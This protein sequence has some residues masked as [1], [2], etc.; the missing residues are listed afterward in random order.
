MKKLFGSILLG[1][2]SFAAVAG[3]N[4]PGAFPSVNT[5][6]VTSGLNVGTTVDY[7]VSPTANTNGVYFANRIQTNYVNSSNIT[8]G[9]YAAGGE[10]VLNISG[11]G[12]NDKEVVT[13]HQLNHATGGN[14]S[15]AI[16]SEAEIASIC[17]TCTIGTYGGFYF[18]NL[19]GL[20][21]VGNITN[22]HAFVNEDARA[23]YK[24]VGR[25]LSY[26]SYS[27]NKE[28]V[29]PAHPGIVAGRYYGASSIVGYG[30]QNASPNVHYFV[31]VHIPEAVT[32]T[33]LG[34]NVQA[35]TAGN[36]RE[37]LYTAVGG[38]PNTLVW[39]TG[40]ISTAAAGDKETTVSLVIKAGPYFL[41][42]LCDTTVSTAW[43]AVGGERM[44]D[45]GG[46]GPL[47]GTE[48][49]FINTTYGALPAGIG[50]LNYALNANQPRLWWRK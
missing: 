40:S 31:P 8:T 4:I 13:L 48:I 33:K 15:L 20:A 24:N 30:A 11:G 46:S 38:F 50:G 16:G 17:A 6:T 36:C 26:N 49:G 28:V 32:V 27:E 44:Y 43:S 25:Y 9:G 42:L 47:N 39:D 19:A 21:N 18:P 2:L 14:T 35:G 29:P 3:I 23:S 34:F 10:H 12:T 41:S 45:L 1:L 22:F 7:N 37:G 5:T